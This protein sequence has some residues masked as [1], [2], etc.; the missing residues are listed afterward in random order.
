MPRLPDVNALRLLVLK[1]KMGAPLFRLIGLAPSGFAMFH[2]GT[3]LLTMT[4]IMLH[5]LL[6]CCAHHAHACCTPTENAKDMELAKGDGHCQHKCGHHISGPRDGQSSEQPGGAGNGDQ[7]H[8]PPCDETRCSF[9]RGERSDDANSAL[10]LI[11]L[12]VSHHVVAVLVQFTSTLIVNTVSH[13][14]HDSL[15]L[16]QLNQVWLI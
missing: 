10:R 15:P 8:H 11:G 12:P 13:D 9:V 1:H 3:T 4:A 14:A 7:D 2:R 6:G 16:H 5:A